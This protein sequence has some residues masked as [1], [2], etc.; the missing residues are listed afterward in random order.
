MQVFHATLWAS[1]PHLPEGPVV[2]LR[3]LP[4]VTR[5][6]DPAG[7]PEPFPL[8]FEQASG[9]MARLD[10]MIVE[11][12]GSFVYSGN[13]PAAWQ[14]EG[15]LFDRD[16]RLLNVQLWGRCPPAAFDRLLKCF[17]WPATQ[18]VFECVRDG[19]YLAEAEFRRFAGLSRS[20]S[21]D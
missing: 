17:D 16:G 10:R 9:K 6:P 5:I 19:V 21:T 12:D 7:T 8:S 20:D 1:S 13:Q 14:V 15:N 11:P 4:L 3:G 18:L 2:P